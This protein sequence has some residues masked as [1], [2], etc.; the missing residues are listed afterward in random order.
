MNK[1][2]ILLFDIETAP[3]QAL[4][5]G[6]WEQ[7]VI[8]VEKDWYM[9]CWAAKWLDNKKIMTSA[10]PDFKD[11]KKNPENDKHVVEAL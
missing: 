5:W 1:P 2:K 7:N 6:M 3:L 8:R 9:L 4:V 10:L 11:Y